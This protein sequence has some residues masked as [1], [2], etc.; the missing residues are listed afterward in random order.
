[1]TATN[2]LFHTVLVLSLVVGELRH[3]YNNGLGYLSPTS[4]RHY[5]D[6]RLLGLNWRLNLTW[7]LLRHKYHKLLLTLSI[8]ASLLWQLNC[9]S[10]WSG[11]GTACNH[12]LAWWSLGL[13]CLLCARPW[14][15]WGNC[16]DLHY[17]RFRHCLFLFLWRLGEA[18]FLHGLRRM[19]N[20]HVF[21]DARLADADCSTNTAMIMGIK[22]FGSTRAWAS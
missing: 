2:S 11:S 6:N 3:W 10:L 12:S 20:A 17:Y 7:H 5:N 15:F 4:L 8:A 9:D 19:V 13:S 22:D 16:W 18:I 21:I 14:S 1:M